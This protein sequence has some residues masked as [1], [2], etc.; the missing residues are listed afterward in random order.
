[1]SAHDEFTGCRVPLDDVA[2]AWPT[3]EG[4]DRLALPEQVLPWAYCSTTTLMKRDRHRWERR[5][6]VK[7]VEGGAVTV[8]FQWFEERIEGS[9]K[10]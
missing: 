8:I 5:A 3:K 4:F 2:Y 9:D 6:H 7:V 1:M 10:A